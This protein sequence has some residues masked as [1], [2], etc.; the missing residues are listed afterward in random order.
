VY[1]ITFF[2]I[3]IFNPASNDRVERLGAFFWTQSREKAIGPDV[4]GPWQKQYAYT[5]NKKYKQ[6]TPCALPRGFS[7]DFE[8]FVGLLLDVSTCL[9]RG[10]VQHNGT[11]I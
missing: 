8:G 10:C 11:L 2:N 3:P 1:K 5:Y 7:N 6:N 4:L 9:I